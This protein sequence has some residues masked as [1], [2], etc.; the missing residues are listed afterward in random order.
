[1]P[2]LLGV[3]LALTFLGQTS[4][5]GIYTLEV[6]FSSAGNHDWATLKIEEEESWWKTNTLYSLG[7][8]V[9]EG[10]SE[11]T[12]YSGGQDLLLFPKGDPPGTIKVYV[13]DSYGTLISNTATVYISPYTS[14]YSVTLFLQANEEEEDP[15]AWYYED[16]WGGTD[17]GTTDGDGGGDLYTGGGDGGGEPVNE[18]PILSGGQV[19]PAEGTPDTL[20]TYAVQYS[21]PNGDEPSLSYV[22]VD[23]AKYP[24][25]YVGGG[26]AQGARFE[27]AMNLPEGA[28]TYHFEFSDGTVT[29]K[30]PATGDRSGP[31]VG[32]D[33]REP[34]LTEASVDP[35]TGLIDD[36]F[37]Y[38]VT[39]MDPDGDHPSYIRLVIIEPDGDESLHS[40][41]P[42]D[43][44]DNDVTDGKVYTHSTTLFEGR[45]TYRFEASDATYEVTSGN[46]MGP[47]VSREN[48][49][50]HLVG[51]VDHY[52]VEPF[53]LVTF[54]GI[55]SDS[56]GDEPLY[57][58]LLVDGL[59]VSMQTTDTTDTIIGRTFTV[60]YDFEEGVYPWGIIASDGTTEARFEGESI[61]VIDNTPPELFLPTARPMEGTDYEFGVNYKDLDGNLAEHVTIVVDGQSY[62]MAP[63]EVDGGTGGSVKYGMLYVATLDLGATPDGTLYRFETS[64]GKDT[65]DTE[66]YRIDAEE[67]DTATTAP[68]RN[69]PPVLQTKTATDQYVTPGRLLVFDVSYYDSESDEP[70]SANIL[71]GT[72][73]PNA[74][75]QWNVNATI[76]PEIM[77]LYPGVDPASGR[78][79]SLASTPDQL[80]LTGDS[81]DGVVTYTF[82]FSF[83]VNGKRYNTGPQ[84]FEVDHSDGT[85]DTPDDGGGGDGNDDGNTTR[86]PIEE[87]ILT[88][89]GETTDGGSIT[90]TVPLLSLE[91]RLTTDVSLTEHFGDTQVL[92]DERT[93]VLFPDQLDEV[94]FPAD[95]IGEGTHTFVAT[96]D[97]E[98]Q[99]GTIAGSIDARLNVT[100]ISTGGDGVA[101]TSGFD[102]SDLG[103]GAGTVAVA[104]AAVGG[105]GGIGAIR[106]RKK[107]NLI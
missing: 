50:P 74:T 105:L 91:T 21:D 2:L 47:V 57:V 7:I 103:G 45:Y 48:T 69:M 14:S 56:D 31:T 71:I 4:A 81:E 12:D 106:A 78:I 13:K 87:P 41:G 18:P 98:D 1:M 49:P 94:I 23:G 63:M 53:D 58:S 90:I 61:T 37:T 27:F 25:D 24:M 29:V 60:Q 75:D 32:H 35:P 15:F 88:Y 20:F 77:P 62:P 73:D 55:F 22:V 68:T 84:T 38:T 102:L 104:V 17:T 26:F 99:V 83:V 28:H 10:E 52:H 40:L 59:N 33:N 101:G 6:K 11:F 93:V 97:Y 95:L 30:D 76:R 96:I 19:L 92:V 85:V 36:D 80:G 9:K 5:Q 16:D 43:Y 107:K 70:S 8:S 86:G 100:V 66:T 39:Y 42:A 89:I 51:D 65:S 64:D 44:G 46:G 79:Y 54:S 34:I 67:G 82:Q 3:F 72:M